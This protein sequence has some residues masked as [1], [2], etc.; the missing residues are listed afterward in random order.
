MFS[1]RTK[2]LVP[3]KPIPKN[4]TFGITAPATTPDPGKLERGV[5]YLESCG[6]QVKVGDTCHREEF[7]VAGPDEARA[8][9]LMDMVDDPQVDAIICARG[10]Y[11]SMRLIKLLDFELFAE[12]RKPLIGFS[13]ITALQWALYAQ[14]GLPSLSAGM[15]ATDM[16]REPFSEVWEEAYWKFLESGEVDYELD[17]EQEEE[18]EIEGL[19]LAGTSSVALKLLGSSYFPDPQGHILILED[20]NEQT[21][22][23][24]SYLLQFALA[25]LFD[26]AAA[27]I[28]GAIRKA[29]LEEYP[30]VPD[31]DTVLKRAFQGT[32]TP[33]VHNLPYG[34]IDDKIPLPIGAPLSLSLGPN[35]SLKS[36][37]SIFDRD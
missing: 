12:Q 22:K 31:L 28:T 19:G 37:E 3:L 16:A 4:A 30:S 10:G 2:T 5:T 35:S 6:Y 25:G 24:E 29:E 9:E 36:T 7:Y 34:H 18:V 8:Y 21:H 15:V 13:D 14:T 32:R 11:G 20:V 17:H 26:R 33:V 1:D 23:I 27:V